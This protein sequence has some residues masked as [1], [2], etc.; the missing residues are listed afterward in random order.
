MQARC[1]YRAA[2]GCP[3]LDGCWLQVAGDPGVEGLGRDVGAVRPDEGP[4]LLVQGDE[5]EVGRVLER[6]EDTTPLPISFPRRRGRL[7]AAGENW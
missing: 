5:V 6:L 7:P 3:M 4:E 1:G 2:H